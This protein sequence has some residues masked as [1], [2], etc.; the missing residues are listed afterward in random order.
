MAMSPEL[1]ARRAAERKREKELKALTTI[2]HDVV[3]EEGNVCKLVIV[4]EG[5]C[6][7][8]QSANVQAFNALLE[9]AG[10]RPIRLTSN[11][12]N[13]QSPTFAIDINTPTYCDPGCDSYHSM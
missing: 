12:L 13:P 9:R 5:A 2:A 10:Y 8:I 11:M 3:V 7:L 4:L 1:I 6:V